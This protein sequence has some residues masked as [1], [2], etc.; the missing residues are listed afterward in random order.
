M[1]DGMLI[2]NK[3]Q[4][5]TSHD[6]VQLARTK[7]GIRR[8]GHAGTLDPMAEGVL[9]L[10]IGQA[11]KFQQRAQTHRKVYEAVMQFGAQTDTGDA[12]GQVIRTAPVPPLSRELIEP[13]LQSLT[14]RIEQTP[15]A[16][17]A[18]KVR[19]RPLYWWTRRGQPQPAPARTVQID[20]LEFLALDGARLRCRIVCSA[21]T[22]IRALAEAIAERLQT[23][24]H[25]CALTRVAVGSWT[26]DVA[27]P[28][29]QLRDADAAEIRRWLKPLAVLHEQVH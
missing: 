22:Y 1:T 11:T 14:G 29:A 3:Q 19:G 20:A 25:V 8:I 9:V 13:V 15:P 4:G 10:L 24:G 28:T 5:M 18:V 2:V 21:G 6:V 16:Y 27:V 12:W 17:S 26:L 23:V 7:L